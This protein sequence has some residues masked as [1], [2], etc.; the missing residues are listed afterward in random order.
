MVVKHALRLV[1]ADARCGWAFTI[2]LA[3]VLTAQPHMAAG[4]TGW[5]VA[6][7]VVDSETGGGLPNALVT[8]EGRGAVLSADGG[9]FRFERVPRGEYRLRAE[10]LG[11][12]D[13][14]VVL[15][16]SHDTTLVVSLDLLPIALEGIEV[17]LGTL[18]FDGRVR[19]PRTDSYVFD[20][21]VR[22]DQGHQESSSLSGR[23]DL[24]DVYDGPPLR[25]VIRAF[26]YL[27][28]DT[29]FV[30]DDEDRYPFDLAPDPV[31]GRMID[32]YVA[33]LDDRAARRIYRY[34]PALNREDLAAFAGNATL[35]M[36]METKYPP[37]IVRRIGCFILDEREYRF[38]SE[39]ERI[40]VWEGTFANEIERI[41]L[42]EFPGYARLFMA[43]VYT[44]WFFQRQVGNPEELDRPTMVATPGGIIC[45]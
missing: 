3:A 11:Y 32:A 20:A 29:T 45:R 43:R 31:M 16:V 39:A 7:R 28:L 2:G 33:R 5:A 36:V 15:D 25:L 14:T 26:R 8:L 10:V 1:R 9:I 42:F 37:H 34:Q 35:R 27:P 38:S 21:D 30:P 40:S 24:D 4:Q 41:E 6:G 13:F 19:D 23:F 12:E 22:S 44:R 17:E 18:D